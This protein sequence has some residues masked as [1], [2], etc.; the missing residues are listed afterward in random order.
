MPS[1]SADVPYG[2]GL[3]ISAAEASGY[4]SQVA[5]TSSGDG[6][7]AR[8]SLG[9]H[10]GRIHRGWIPASINPA[11]ADLCASR[12]ISSLPPPAVAARMH[13]F[14][15]SELPQVEKNACSAP[16]RVRHQLL[17]ALQVA[18]G[19]LP[20]TQPAGGQHVRPERVPT[21][22]INQPLVD[23]PTLTV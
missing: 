3:P 2:V 4:R 19:G 16:H 6:G 1:I 7:C 5:S 15:D 12:E 22:H 11:A 13:A 21:H 20:V 9:S 8:C 10:R 23:A 17:G 14:T 18:V